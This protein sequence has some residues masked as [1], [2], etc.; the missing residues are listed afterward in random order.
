MMF[1][2][3]KLSHESGQWSGVKA[4]VL[5]G[6]GSFFWMAAWRGMVR[7]VQNSAVEKWKYADVV[8]LQLAM[9]NGVLVRFLP[10]SCFDQE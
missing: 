5:M 10:L 4:S 8:W 9:M 6:V 3:P 1:S 7:A 2:R